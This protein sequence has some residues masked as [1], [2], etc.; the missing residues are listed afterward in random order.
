MLIAHIFSQVFNT[1]YQLKTTTYILQLF[2]CDHYMWVRQYT[3]VSC[4]NKI[5]IYIHISIM[6]ECDIPKNKKKPSRGLGLFMSSYR[7]KFITH[8]WDDYGYIRDDNYFQWY[9][10]F[11]VKLKVKSWWSMVEVDNTYRSLLSLTS[12][13]ALT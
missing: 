10:V 1:R 3:I 13:I 5:T 12:D 11:L 4:N 2:T 8:I 9:D 7:L 6:H